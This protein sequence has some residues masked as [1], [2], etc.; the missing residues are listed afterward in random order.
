[1]ALAIRAIPTLTGENAERFIAA[2]EATE[3]NPQ[4]VKLR[5]SREDVHKMMEK[6]RNFKF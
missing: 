3:K 1:M 5:V 6:S 2:A 4:K